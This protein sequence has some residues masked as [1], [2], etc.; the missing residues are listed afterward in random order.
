M[1][2]A[3]VTPRSFYTDR[4]PRQFNRALD[5]ESEDAVRAD[6]EAVN[7]TLKV[8]VEGDD[9]GT[10]FLNIEKGRMRAGDSAAFAPFLTIVHDRAAFEV[11]ERESGDSALSFLGGIAGLAGELKL[12]ASR[13]RNLAEL[14]GGVR[15]ELVGDG[16]FA[17]LTHFGQ[18]PVAPESKCSIT[19]DAEAYRQLQS[20]EINAQDAFMS[21]KIQVGGDMQ[22][23]MQLALA[24]LSPD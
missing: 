20:G 22:M 11:I 1:T 21:G 7:A 8:V 16:G 6:L 18:E 5:A 12:T 3:D 14:E 13:I 4:I 19:V 15:F 9:G 2:D 24:A 23:A 17:I 10:F